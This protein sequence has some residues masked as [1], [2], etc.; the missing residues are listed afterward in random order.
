VNLVFRYRNP[1]AASA[2]GDALGTLAQ[3]R[4]GHQGCPENGGINP[5]ACQPDQ[6][7]QPGQFGQCRKNPLTKTPN[8]QGRNP[9]LAAGSQERS[10]AILAASFW[11]AEGGTPPRSCP[12]PLPAPTGR[13]IPAQCN[14][15]GIGIVN[16]WSPEGAIHNRCRG[17]D[18][19]ANDGV[20]C[21]A[22]S[23]LG[24]LGVG[25]F[26]GRCPRLVC[27][28]PLGLKNLAG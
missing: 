15:L 19:P 11:L 20:D 28:A 13:H 14:A 23:G 1:P 25:G 2:R 18:L 3:R 9:S 4:Q 17:H 27:I 16:K 22:L 5:S 10:V 8:R 12:R 21:I 24:K 6:S 7:G 26:L